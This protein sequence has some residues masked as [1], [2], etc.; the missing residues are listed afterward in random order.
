[1]REN[2]KS[3]VSCNLFIFL[4]ESN[5]V[6]G[7]DPFHNT[8]WFYDCC[9]FVQCHYGS[10][11]VEY[12]YGNLI[13]NRMPRKL[14]K[15]FI[16]RFPVNCWIE[17]LLFIKAGRT[18]GYGGKVEAVFKKALNTIGNQLGLNEEVYGIIHIQKA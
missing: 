15:V 8:Y 12:G 14:L 3:E 9:P 10:F 5:L 4:C 2:D 17:Q 6:K 13:T 16:N 18:D 7:F 11:L 1:M